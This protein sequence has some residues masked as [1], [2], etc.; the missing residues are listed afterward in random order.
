MQLLPG[1]G[2]SFDFLANPFKKEYELLTSAQKKT[3]SRKVYELLTPKMPEL[4]VPVPPPS[5]EDPSIAEA[6]KK[7]KLAELQRRGRSAMILTGSK[8][9][10]DELGNV[11]RPQATAVKLFG[12]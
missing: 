10:E 7:Q 8:G 9:V 1:G 6:R 3:G 11:T 2:D 5:R 12:E 4:P